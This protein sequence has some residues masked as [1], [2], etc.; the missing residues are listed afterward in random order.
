MKKRFLLA[1]AISVAVVVCLFAS[2]VTQA[3]PLINVEKSVSTISD[4][5]GADPGDSIEDQPIFNEGQEI[6]FVYEY[7]ITNTSETDDITYTYTMTDSDPNVTEDISGTVTVMAGGT[8]TGIAAVLPKI[9]Q[10]DQYSSVVT[11]SVTPDE[12]EVTTATDNLYYYGIPA[13][14]EI[15]IDIKPGSDTN[16]INLRS[17]GLVPVALIDFDPSILE[18]ATMTF[19]GAEALRWA[20]EDVDG[21][22]DLDVICHFRTQELELDRDSINAGVEIGT[23]DEIADQ[24]VTSYAGEDTVSIVPKGKAKG[25]VKNGTSSASNKGSSGNKGGNGKNKNK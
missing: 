22:G 9:A 4:G 17:Q 11:L 21:D 7:S 13:A 15:V 10:A 14:E 20:V 18:G 1:S 19:A 3:A 2:S 12:V 6:Y 25:H 23:Y 16:P 8:V 24:E 5:S